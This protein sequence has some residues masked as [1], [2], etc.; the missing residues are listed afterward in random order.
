MTR[1]I[2]FGSGDIELEGIYTE[3]SGNTASVITHPHPLY[4]GDMN[5]NV[6]VSLQMAFLNTDISTLRFNFRGVGQSGGAYDGGLGEQDDVMAAMNHLLGLGKDRIFLAGY[7]FGAWINAKASGRL[8]H[9][10][11]FLVAPPVALLDFPE[12]R[13]EGLLAVIAGEDD[14]FGPPD[15]VF[16]AAQK[17]NPEARFTMIP[18]ADHFFWGREEE[19]QSAIISHLP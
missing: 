6:V 17:W 19:L 1:Q 2:R 8:G 3:A 15:M 9:P 18:H 5:S 16:E 7:S 13:I 10:P 4:G 11:M 14:T 12:D